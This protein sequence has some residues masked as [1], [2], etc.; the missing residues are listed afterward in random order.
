MV[1]QR[2]VLHGESEPRIAFLRGILEAAPGGLE[3]MRHPSS[4]S[5]DRISGSQNGAYR[6]FYFGEYQPSA[7]AMGLPE[8]VPFTVD[9]ID[10]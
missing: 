3:P 10:P 4:T 9:L 6:L 2:G 8:D 1:V 5:W 7:W